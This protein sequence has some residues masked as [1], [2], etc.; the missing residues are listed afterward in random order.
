MVSDDAFPDG[1]LTA[2][3]TVFGA[4]L[5]LFSSFGQMSAFGTFQSWY[6]AHQL[7]HMNAD[8]ISW[9]GSIQLWVFFFSGGFIG[10]IFDLCGS[11]VMMSL[12]T[13]IYVC[14]LMATSVAT[15]YYQFILTQGI[16]FGLG[17]GLLFY[18]ALAAIST[19]FSKRRATALGIAS[20]GSGIG[21]TVYPILLQRLFV[22][23][24]FAWG[25]R[26]SGFICLALCAVSVCTITSHPRPQ[27]RNRSARSWFDVKM[28]H[29][30][31]FI[32]LICGSCFI[33]LG[34]FTPS[35][36]LVSYATAHGV[37]TAT[38]F[39]LLAI[40]NGGSVLGR[41]APAPL[42]D[43]YGRL[44]LLVP[45]TFLAGLTTLVLWSLAHTLAPLVVYAALYGVFS[46]AFNALIVPCVAQI[47]DVRAVGS[48]IGLLYSVISF[49]S[50]AG[51]PVAGALLKAGNSYTGLIML[52]GTSVVVGSA[53]MMWAKLAIDRRVFA[54]V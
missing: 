8:A 42:A 28:L 14:S 10:R 45:C 30:K 27:P 18:P 44:A 7:Q 35:F 53:F 47:S 49:P 16:L 15:K 11:R 51:G 2:W 43:T 24:N 41:L 4:F 33:A 9:I 32:L 52:S 17:V 23:L 36:Y 25:V 26:I 20:V 31:P 48:R 50:L 22:R 13:L 6:A 46:G 19:H 3:L 5:A 39:S 12:G 34:L 40:L 37:P 29:D 21:G 38:A 54:S 1:G